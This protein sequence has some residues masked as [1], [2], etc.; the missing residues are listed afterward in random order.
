MTRGPD[1]DGDD[2]ENNED[3]AK[4]EC[5][6]PR[7][8]YMYSFFCVNPSEQKWLPGASAAVCL[9]PTDTTAVTAH[10]LLL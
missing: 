10:G 8:F 9:C 2:D 4:E 1:N 6:K 5:V 7:F 3:E